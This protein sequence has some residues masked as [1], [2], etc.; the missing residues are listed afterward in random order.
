VP[1]LRRLIVAAIAVVLPLTLQSSEV[2][3]AGNTGAYSFLSQ[4]SGHSLVARW[5]PCTPISYRVNTERAPEGSLREVRQ[6]F[7]RVARATGLSFRYAGKT[8]VVPGPSPMDYPADTRIVV[9][10]VRPGI[11]TPA[12][13]SSADIAGYGGAYYQ[14]GYTERGEEALVITAG[15][16]VLNAPMAA[17]MG[18]GF[19]A[20]P[21]GGTGEL[22]MHELGH[23][24][25]LAHPTIDDPA[26]IMHAE[27]TGKAAA[28]GAGDLT[29][30]RQVGGDGGCLQLTPPTPQ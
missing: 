10:W 30:L 1:L 2:Y 23:A 19:G 11:D 27:L 13:P 4:R 12:F 18:R 14:P 24:V 22:L 21:G 28:W 20:Q 8:D 16:V 6:A 7:D 3:A 29:G 25:G 15:V 26:E 9:A 17:T 5:D